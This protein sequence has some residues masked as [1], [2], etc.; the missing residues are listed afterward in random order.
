ML[1]TTTTTSI[2]CIGR[3]KKSVSSRGIL[4]ASTSRIVLESSFS[5]RTTNVIV[6]SVIVIVPSIRCYYI[7]RVLVALFAVAAIANTARRR[8]RQIIERRG[9][10]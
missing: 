3:P 4:V 5:G 8:W 7:T 2:V 1:W 10:Y 9:Y 6:V